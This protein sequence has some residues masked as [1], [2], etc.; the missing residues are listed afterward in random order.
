M[1]VREAPDH[2]FIRAAAGVAC[3]RTLARHPGPS[4]HLHLYARCWLYLK[5]TYAAPFCPPITGALHSALHVLRLSPP[6][7]LICPRDASLFWNV[8]ARLLLTCR[9]R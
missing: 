8:A 9:S 5:Q 2:C 7:P 1:P 4:V 6:R 3:M